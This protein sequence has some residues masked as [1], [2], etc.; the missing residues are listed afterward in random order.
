MEYEEDR[1]HIDE[2]LK[3]VCGTDYQ[4]DEKKGE[5]SLRQ[6]SYYELLFD[7]K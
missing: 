6:H 7:M 5:D 3:V 1:L 2:F 4:R